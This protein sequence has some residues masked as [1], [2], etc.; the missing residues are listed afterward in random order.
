MQT[1]YPLLLLGVL[2]LF[3][4]AIVIAL[5]RRFAIKAS[6]KFPFALVS[7]ETKDGADAMKL[8]KWRRL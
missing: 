4:A 2:V 5:I 3:F 7:F 6:L 8:P 1:L